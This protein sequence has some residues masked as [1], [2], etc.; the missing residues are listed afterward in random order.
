MRKANPD[1]RREPR[2]ED[3]RRTNQI[4][5]DSIDNLHKHFCEQPSE[6][7]ANLWWDL[8]IALRST[9]LNLSEDDINEIGDMMA[10]L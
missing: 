9:G 5:R 6:A 3:D 4:L 1:R 2:T 7:R 8:V 10:G